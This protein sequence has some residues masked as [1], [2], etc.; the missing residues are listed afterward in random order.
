MIFH[1]GNIGNQTKGCTAADT[2]DHSIQSDGR[3]VFTIRLGTDP[4]ITEKHHCFLTRFMYQI[5]Q[6]FSLTAYKALCKINILL[7][8]LC[9]NTERGIIIAV[10]YKNL[11]AQAIA[12]FLFKCQYCFRGYT[13]TIAAPVYEFFLRIVIENQR[14]MI[15]ERCKAHNITALILF[16]LQPVFQIFH[17]IAA[18][19]RLAYIKRYFMRLVTPVIGDMIVHLC[20]IPENIGKKADRIFMERLCMMHDNRMLLLIQLPVICGNHSPTGTVNN[21][22]P[23]LGIMVVI[24]CDL[25]IEVFFGKCNTDI[26]FGCQCMRTHQINLLAFLHVLFSEFIMPSGYEICGIYLRIQIP[27]SF[28]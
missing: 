20:R 13:G 23:L 8:F 10:L 4:V 3:K 14:K 25:L 11:R 21:L 9:R 18:A 7:I 15:E 2:S 16:L 1:T 6:L 12:L 27:D 26:I 19:E 24:R 17:N 28:I 22:P 5:H